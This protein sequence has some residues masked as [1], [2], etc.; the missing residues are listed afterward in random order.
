MRFG[1]VKMEQ[2]YQISGSNSK[3]E[4]Y[5]DEDHGL[6]YVHETTGWTHQN[7]QQ[8]SNILFENLAKLVLILLYQAILL[9]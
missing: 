2:F 8:Q 3:A 4:E 5:H 7:C 9:L 6:V 1:F